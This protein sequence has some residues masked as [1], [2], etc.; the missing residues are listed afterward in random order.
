MSDVTASREVT[1]SPAAA[2]RVTVLMVMI[3][4]G[5][6]I[7]GGA[8]NPAVALGACVMGLLAWPVLWVYLLAQ[9]AGGA[10]AGLAF[11]ALNPGDK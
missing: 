5:G 8:F 2:H 7:S 11:L 6:H 9:L 10:A 3:Y 1:G 4:A